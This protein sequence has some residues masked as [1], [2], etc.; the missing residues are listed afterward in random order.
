MRG[1]SEGVPLSKISRSEDSAYVGAIG[2]ALEPLVPTSAESSGTT[3]H[4]DRSGLILSPESIEFNRFLKLILLEHTPLLACFGFVT[5]QKWRVS[6]KISVRKRL[7]LNDSGVN[8]RDLA[9]PRFTWRAFQRGSYGKR[10]SIWKRSL[11]HK[12]FTITHKNHVA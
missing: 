9:R 6:I 2:L 5:R 10:A 11:L 4:A 12:C 7:N 3:P 1:I 8:I